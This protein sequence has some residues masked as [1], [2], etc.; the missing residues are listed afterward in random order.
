[1]SATVD[2]SSLRGSIKDLQK[3]SAALDEE[4][5]AAELEFKKLLEKMRQVAT[6]ARQLEKDCMEKD[7]GFWSRITSWLPFRKHDDH[8]QRCKK[9]GR[10]EK[11]PMHINPEIE[12]EEGSVGHDHGEHD[13]HRKG[14]PGHHDEL[15]FLIPAEHGH[16]RRPFGPMMKDVPIRKFIKAAK[17][18][19]AANKK[20]SSFERGFISKEG[21]KDREWYKHLGVAPGKLLGKRR[22]YN[23][24]QLRS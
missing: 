2:F 22:S 3:A 9:R 24:L 18:V 19:K 23:I 15:D 11:V 21:I 17:R 1:M 4:K 16:P 5:E 10:F 8:H 7:D 13:R 6:E 14:H 12:N 20:L